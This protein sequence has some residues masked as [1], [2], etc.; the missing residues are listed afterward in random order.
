MVVR[1]FWKARV[2]LKRGSVMIELLFLY[3][4]MLQTKQHFAQQ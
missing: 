4:D 3:A 2:F 1:I